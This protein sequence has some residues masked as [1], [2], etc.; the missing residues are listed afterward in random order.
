MDS[1]RVGGD[2]SERAQGWPSAERKALVG[3]GLGTA[4]TTGFL[5][6]EAA[7]TL[8]EQLAL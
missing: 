4:T 8:S 1:N 5:G 3:G 6:E 7:G 2:C